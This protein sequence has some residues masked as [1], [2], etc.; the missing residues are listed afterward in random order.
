MNKAIESIQKVQVPN[1]G[2]I[3]YPIIAKAHTAM[4]LVHSYDTRKPESVVREYIRHYCPPCGI[5]LDMFMGA[6]P[7][8]IEAVALGR[9]AIG[10]EINPLAYLIVRTTLDYVDLSILRR[11]AKNLKEKILESEY[12]IP[13]IKGEEVKIRLPDLYVTKCPKCGLKAVIKWLAYSF[14]VKCPSCRNKI[15]I[16]YCEKG[17]R[18]GQYYCTNCGKK[19]NLNAADVVDLQLVLMGY[20]CPAHK[21]E[22]VKIPG[23]DDIAL[24]KRIEKELDIPYWVPDALFYYPHERPFY[25]KRRIEDIRSLFD[26]RTLITLS[27]IYHEINSMVDTKLREL[28]KL[29]FSAMLEFV[30]RLNPLRPKDKFKAGTSLSQYS[31]FST[32]SGLTVHE[33]WVPAVHCINN[34]LIIFFERVEKVIKGKMESVERLKNVVYARD[35][36]D[37]LKGEANVLLIKDSALNLRQYLCEK[38]QKDPEEKLK[39]PGCIDFI[40]TD[41][42]YGEAIQTY[43]LDFFRNAWLFPK[44]LNFWKDEIVIN[45][46]QGKDINY[47]YTMLRRVFTDAFKVLKPGHYMVVTFHSR[48]IKVYNTVIRAAYVSGFELDKIVFQP[49]AVRSAKQSLHPYTSAVGDYYIRFKKPEKYNEHVLPEKVDERVFEREVIKEIEEIVAQ[50]GEPTS[51]TDILKEIYPRLARRGFL[52][53]AKPEKIE[54]IL[55]KYSEVE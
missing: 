7:M 3:N 54:E 12:L 18:Q 31:D 20:R 33:L 5:V 48:F 10:F 38:C 24:H 53:Y 49:P 17:K 9:R 50:R 47:Y 4:Y 55:R 39:C 1:D 22:G 26:K 52:L 16:F 41:P 40:F 23:K 27:I 42:P 25:T 2:H 45:P 11:E 13:T 15:S 32:R 43:E 44:E 37:I 46:S 21:H 35:I 28:F 51:I 30:C 29:A 36:N 8:I 6:G 34:P 19:F 14:I